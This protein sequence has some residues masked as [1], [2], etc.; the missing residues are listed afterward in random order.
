MNKNCESSW[1]FTKINLTE[2]LRLKTENIYH[3]KI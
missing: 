1:L 3:K 2:D